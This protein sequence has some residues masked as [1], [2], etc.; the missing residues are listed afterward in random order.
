MTPEEL[1]ALRDKIAVKP[2]IRDAS[3]PVDP[4]S[5]SGGY[6]LKNVNERIKVYFGEAY[7]IS[8]E[9]EK[10]VGTSVTIH[11]PKMQEHDL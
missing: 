4:Y 5:E 10:N 8:I 3:A 9:S 6:G 11:I 7:G 1:Q 2:Q